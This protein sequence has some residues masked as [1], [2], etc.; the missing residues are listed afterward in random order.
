MASNDHHKCRFDK[1]DSAL[2]AAPKMPRLDNDGSD[3]S[4]RHPT[5]RSWRSPR[6][7]MSTQR[8]ENWPRNIPAP[9]TPTPR[10][11]MTLSAT[12]MVVTPVVTMT[13]V[14]MMMTAVMM[15][16]SI[17]PSS[18]TRTSRFTRAAVMCVVHFVILT[19]LIRVLF[20]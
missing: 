20:M 17:L 5:S 14:A 6:R 2:A 16:T 11:R 1:D 3:S 13:T 9:T 10:Q 8:R 18:L 19:S 12:P 15:T 4:S 7:S